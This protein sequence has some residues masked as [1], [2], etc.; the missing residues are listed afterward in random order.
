MGSRTDVIG[1]KR[2]LA[3]G[4][5]LVDVLPASIFEQEHLPGAMNVPLETFTAGTVAGLDR[6]AALV[7][8]CFDQH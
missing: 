8:Y 7:V 6:D 1:A 4:A 5:Q 2:L 3:D